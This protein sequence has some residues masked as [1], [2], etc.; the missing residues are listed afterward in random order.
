MIRIAPSFF[1]FELH[2]QME[3]LHETPAWV[4]A[5][6]DSGVKAGATIVA[7]NSGSIWRG[8]QNLLLPALELGLGAAAINVPTSANYEL[9]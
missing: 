7:M 5:S 6:M 4:I 3:H 1:D 2:R 9:C 8:I